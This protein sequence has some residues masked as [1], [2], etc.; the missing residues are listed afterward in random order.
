MSTRLLIC[1]DLDRTLLPNGPQPESPDAR[2]RFNRLAA[3]PGIT[4]VYVTGRD[5]VLVEEAIE[6]YRL[7]QPVHQSSWSHME[8]WQHEISPDWKGC[9][10]DDMRRLFADIPSLTLQ[11]EAKQNSYKLSYYVSLDTDQE[12]LMSEMQSILDSN[13]I[14]ASLIWSI[15]ELAATGLLDVLPASASK[16]HAIEFLMRQLDYD[17]S[18]TIFAGDSGN[19]LAVLISPIRS[20]LVANASAEVRQQAEQQVIDNGHS[21]ALYFAEGD[22]LGMN[23]NYSA[24]ILEGVAHY[25][26]ETKNIMDGL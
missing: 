25:A 1:T 26:P 17:L 23:G 15:D 21:D 11:P 6:E 14:R 4:L 2:Q 3:H 10:H 13:D 7:P 24:G 18:N 8:K 22:F 20:V 5:Q 9:T 19:D 12:L 16:S